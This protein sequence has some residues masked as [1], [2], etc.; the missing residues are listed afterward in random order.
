MKLNR[1]AFLMALFVVA[2]AVQAQDHAAEQAKTSSVRLGDKVIVI[3]D[4]PGYEEATSQFPKY[5]ERILATEGPDNDTLLAHLPVS[6]CE[7]LRKDSAATYNQYTKVSVLRAARN[8]TVSPAMM[9]EAVAS[10]RQ[11]LGAYLDPNGPMLKGLLNKAEKGLSEVDSKE[12]KIDLSDPRQLGEFDVRPDIDSFLVL[13]TVNVNSGG[14]EVTVPMLASLSFVRLKERL[15]YVYVFRKYRAQADIEEV[16]QFATRWATS[17]V[18]AN[19]SK[20]K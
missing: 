1:Y 19:T 12:T 18:A 4:P 8:V 13:M 10:F 14:V 17:I 9:A 3:P 6:D 5:K 15:I 11:N 16:K 7:L 2:T 20:D